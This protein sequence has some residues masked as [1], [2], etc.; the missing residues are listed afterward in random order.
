MGEKI[1]GAI[2]G[3]SGMVGP[4]ALLSMGFQ[5]VASCLL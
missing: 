2:V 1:E 3:V 4:T 5:I